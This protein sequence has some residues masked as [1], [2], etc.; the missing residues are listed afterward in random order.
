MTTTVK[1]GQ[2]SSKTGERS[3]RGRMAVRRSS[4]HHSGRRKKRKALLYD[5]QELR[6][7]QK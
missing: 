4:E 7:L 5:P 6:L 3:I 1:T 2:R